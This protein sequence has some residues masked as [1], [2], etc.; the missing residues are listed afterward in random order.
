MKG[1]SRNH[2]MQMEKV[3]RDV[4]KANSKMIPLFRPIPRN[5]VPGNYM[6]GT[7]DAAVAM[8]TGVR[9]GPWFWGPIRHH[10]QLFTAGGIRGGNYY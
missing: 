6:R 3:E 10:G 9:S 7:M 5:M 8:R 4:S 2:R 1:R